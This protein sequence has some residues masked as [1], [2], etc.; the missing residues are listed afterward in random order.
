MSKTK[1][2]NFYK[3]YKINE[4]VKVIFIEREERW[5]KNHKK[6]RH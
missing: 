6:G 4:K 5:K 2:L 1:L 3:K